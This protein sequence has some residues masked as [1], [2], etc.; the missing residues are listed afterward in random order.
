MELGSPRKVPSDSNDHR[1]STVRW[2][3][4][5]TDHSPRGEKAL[6][7]PES[8]LGKDTR[9]CSLIGNGRLKATQLRP[10]QRTSSCFKKS[11]PCSDV[12]GSHSKTQ[13]VPLRKGPNPDS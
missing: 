9:H 5:P 3:S 10:H 4:Y 12:P 1:K 13:R 2:K 7:G 11:P 6:S 8:H